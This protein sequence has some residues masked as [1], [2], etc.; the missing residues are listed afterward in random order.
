M[1][2]DYNEL[3]D[4]IDTKDEDIINTN[5]KLI[6]SKLANFKGEIDKFFSEKN[7]ILNSV[8]SDITGLATIE[9]VSD[10]FKI[11]DNELKNYKWRTEDEMSKKVNLEL[12]YRILGHFDTFIHNIDNQRMLTTKKIQRRDLKGNDTK[13]D[14]LMNSST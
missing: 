5:T 13:T 1:R 6:E 4:I 2:F 8:K 10:K 3:R 11:I 7:V 14:N 9:Q 12:I